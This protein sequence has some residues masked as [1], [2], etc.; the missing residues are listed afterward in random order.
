MNLQNTEYTSVGQRVLRHLLSTK[1]TKVGIEASIISGSLGG[2]PETT[3]KK[4]KW[5]FLG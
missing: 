2:Y 1:S 5:S 3:A 4:P